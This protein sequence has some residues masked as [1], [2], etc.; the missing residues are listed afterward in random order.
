MVRRICLFS[1]FVVNFVH[2]PAFASREPVQVV[3]AFTNS[4]FPTSV[5]KFEVQLDEMGEIQKVRWSNPSYQSVPPDHDIHALTRSTALDVYQSYKTIVLRG[6]PIDYE[7]GEGKFS[8]GFLG[9]NGYLRCPFVL[10]KGDQGWEMHNVTEGAKSQPIRHVHAV[11]G[12]LSG[13]EQ[14]TGGLRC[15]D[16]VPEI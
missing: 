8:F 9:S 3:A 15:R 4:L 7:K 14:I 11:M 12:L 16:A 10:R 1:V 2:W 13:T 6:G 5:A